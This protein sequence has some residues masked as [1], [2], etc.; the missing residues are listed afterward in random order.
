MTNSEF[1][2]HIVVS[3]V[4]SY[5]CLSGY[6]SCSKSVPEWQHTS[7]TPKRG[8]RAA[9]DVLSTVALLLHQAGAQGQTLTVAEAQAGAGLVAGPLQDLGWGVAAETEVETE[10]P[11]QVLAVMMVGLIA[12]AEVS[13]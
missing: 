10:A 8:E 7:R 1:I 12:E 6:N 3:L 13:K 11:S 2:V 9:F 4:S 5:R